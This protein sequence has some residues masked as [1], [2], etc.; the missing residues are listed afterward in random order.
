MEFG[1]HYAGWLARFWDPRTSNHWLT[2]KTGFI[3]VIV[4]P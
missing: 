3:R 1:I 4:K 2:Y